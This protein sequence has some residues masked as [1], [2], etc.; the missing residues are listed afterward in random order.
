MTD[1][2]SGFTLVEL[3]VSIAVSASLALVAVPQY[4]VAVEAGRVDRTTSSLRSL[5]L[6]QRMYS[7][8][9]GSFANSLGDLVTTRLAPP[10]VQHRDGPFFFS[11]VIADD[12]TFV[13]EAR[14]RPGEAWSGTFVIDQ[15]GTVTGWVSHG[16]G[17]VVGPPSS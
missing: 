9:N 8:E 4:M 2:R 7:M 16:Q 13:V 5:W 6:A 14:R 1:R 10:S 11:V 17:L 15:T 12:D 3:V